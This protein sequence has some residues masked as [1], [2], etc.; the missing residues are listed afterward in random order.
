M[1]V[2]SYLELAKGMSNEQSKISDLSVFELSN[3]GHCSQPYLDSPKILPCCG[4]TICSTCIEQLEKHVQ[5]SQFKCIVCNKQET[6]PHKGFHV[7]ELALK[8]LANSSLDCSQNMLELEIKIEKIKKA[9][10]DNQLNSAT[11][12][13]NNTDVNK[14]KVIKIYL[15]F[16][17]VPLRR[18][19]I[20]MVVNSN[21]RGNRHCY[22]YRKRDFYFINSSLSP[23]FYR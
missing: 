6:I 21:T 9:L 5:N 11:N 7:N 3:C 19:F 13:N 16:I 17:I 1:Q 23:W 18:D 10:V 15:L 22:K 4:K 2:N 14:F 12:N 8:M 20:A